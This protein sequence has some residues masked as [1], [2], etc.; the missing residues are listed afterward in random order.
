[1]NFDQR[2]YKQLSRDLKKSAE[3]NRSIQLRQIDHIQY[4][5]SKR[6]AYKIFFIGLFCLIAFS[7]L[8]TKL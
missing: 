3:E 2:Y 6:I 4:E 5:E 1:M 7:W 8:S